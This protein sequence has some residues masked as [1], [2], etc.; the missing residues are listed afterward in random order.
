VVGILGIYGM[1]RKLGGPKKIS[2]S[3]TTTASSCSKQPTRPPLR[4]A[5]SND[6][7]ASLPGRIPS[8]VPCYRPRM[9]LA[10]S[11]TNQDHKR[12]VRSAQLSVNPVSANPRPFRPTPDHGYGILPF[13]APFPSLISTH[14]DN[15]LELPQR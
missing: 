2:R 3:Q 5:P 4:T 1:Y 15:W 8:E 9:P 11:P 6:Y 10:A 14:A 13:F 12:L 7:H